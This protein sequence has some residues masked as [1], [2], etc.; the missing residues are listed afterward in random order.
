MASKWLRMLARNGCL[1]LSSLRRTINMRFEHLNFNAIDYLL[2]PVIEERFARTLQR[3]KTR[4]QLA[5]TDVDNRQILSLLETIA[6][7]RHYLK[8][9]A[10]RTAGK[11]IFVE[12]D[13]IDWIGAAENYVELHIGRSSQLL[14][15][16]MN[17]LEKSL[18]PETFVRIHRSTI[19]NVN[20]IKEL[21]PA[22]HGE[23]V[24]TL[25][26]GM[27]LQSGRVYNDKLKALSTNPF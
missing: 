25:Q 14:H 20:R 2:K 15:V 10:V 17:T 11:I 3:V 9:L 7:P 12:V 22:L 21:Q 5:P 23:Y 26:D 6:S 13:E 16:T 19:V 8:R 27:R 4:L 18:D 1:R 24:V